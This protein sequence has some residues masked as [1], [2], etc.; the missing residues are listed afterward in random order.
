MATEKHDPKEVVSTDNDAVSTDNK[1]S[2]R[3]LL[4]KAA[5]GVP[6]A[7]TLAHK[8]AFGAICSISGFQSVNP[9]G[10]NA[11]QTAGPGCGG[12]SPGGWKQNGFKTK[13]QDGNRNQWLAAGFNPNP[14]PGH[15]DPQAFNYDG[16]GT[17]FYA[18]NAFSGTITSGITIGKND[19]LHDV[20]LNHPGSLE[21]HAI[22]NL[23]NAKYFSDYRLA[24]TDVVGLYDAYN[25][26]YPD[27]TT[28]TGTLV[29]LNVI[30]SN[31][32]LQTFFDQYHISQY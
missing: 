25:R 26:G 22:A 5:M 23:L 20:L 2:R 6:L 4:T 12:Y 10:V 9:S 19:T 13:N 31:G 30:A 17:L 14:R 21:C 7:L 15:D 11:G 28:S 32:G 1:I 29:K 27:Y 16:A 18:T 8:P 3:G 24:A